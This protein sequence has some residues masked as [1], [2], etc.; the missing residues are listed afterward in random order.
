MSTFGIVVSLFG[1]LLLLWRIPPKLV[2][3]GQ[4][5]YTFDFVKRGVFEKLAAAYV[6]YQKNLC[7]FDSVHEYDMAM[8]GQHQSSSQVAQLRF[9]VRAGT[10]H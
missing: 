7:P 10:W 3:D 4:S 8:E 6:Y 1:L 2:C 5:N 9:S